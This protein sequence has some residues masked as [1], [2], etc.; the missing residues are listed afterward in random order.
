MLQPPL[1]GCAR[2][3][4]RRRPAGR[5]TRPRPSAQA[6]LADAQG[7]QVGTVTL[8]RFAHGVLIHGALDGLPP[9]WHGFHIH[10]TGACT[11]NFAAAGGHFA[12]A[13]AKHGLEADHMHVG[14]LPNIWVGADGKTGFEF[15]THLVTLDDGPAGLLKQGGTAFVVHAQPDDYTGQPAGNAGDRIACGVIKKS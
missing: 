12:G 2:R 1:R 13:G 11:P 8:T 6:A 5:R 10:E 3:R 7:R 15:V 14:D 9:G 4:P